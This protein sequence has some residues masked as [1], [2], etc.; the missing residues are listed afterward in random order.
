MPEVPTEFPQFID[1]WMMILGIILPLIIAKINSP[2][3]QSGT[4]SFVAFGVVLIVATGH[5]FFIGHWDSINWMQTV[6]KI[7]FIT[8]VTF[9]GFWKPTGIADRI[10]KG[11]K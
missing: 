7:F 10:E 5:V 11:A 9:Q 4:K 6:M 1:M 2:D 3:W 8:I